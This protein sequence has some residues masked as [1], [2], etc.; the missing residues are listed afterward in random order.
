M[1]LAGAQILFYPTAIGWHPQEKETY[2][3]TQFNAWIGVQKG[4]AIA[5]GMYVA[6]AN[7]TGFEPAPK[8]ESGIEFWGNSFVA[9]PQGQIIAQANSQPKDTILYADI[10]LNLVEETRQHWP[11]LRDRRCDTYQDLS[12][13]AR[14]CP[15]PQQT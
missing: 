9:D 6:T 14:T 7:R 3:T 2:G 10:D 11:F 13:L 15:P 5:N 1:A 8:G 4:H 12:Q